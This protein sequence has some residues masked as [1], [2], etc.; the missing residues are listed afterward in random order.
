[1][2]SRSR[3]PSAVEGGDVS[4]HPLNAGRRPA[5]AFLALALVA[6]ALVIAASSAGAGGAS[7]AAEAFA[8]EVIPAGQAPAVGGAAKAPPDI[9]SLGGSFA[10][11]DDG[12]I[13]SAA[14]T[15][16]S[17]SA[18]GATVSASTRIASLSLFGG[19]ITADGVTAQLRVGGTVD[20]S[21]SGFTNLVVLGQ[22]VQAQAG[23][24]IQLADWGQ[25][26]LLGASTGTDSPLHGSLVALDVQLTADH[27]G[28]AAGSE[29]IVG[30]VS[31]TAGSAAPPITT[32][33]TP[34]PGSK[35]AVAPVPVRPP[36]QPLTPR[37]SKQA[38]GVP[39]RV[40]PP[41]AGG[42]YVF[43]V[44][45]PSSFG[46]TFGAFRA[47]VSYHHGDDIFA[48]LGT[49]L[50]AVADGTLFSVGVNPIGGNRLWLRDRAGNE[51]YYAHLSA[52]STLAH[53]GAEVHAGDVIGFVGDTGDARG[54]PYHLHF[55]IHP[56][57]YLGLGYDGAVDPTTYLEGWKHLQSVNPAELARG[58]PYLT[59]SP[60]D[61]R[62]GAIL[63][64]VTD[65]SSAS[66]LQPESLERALA[67][68]SRGQL[69]QLLA[70][71]RAAT[72][73]P[74]TPA[75]TKG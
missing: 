61:A 3:P 37:K 72:R 8:V 54:T 21:G 36:E 15:S 33:T 68:S 51:F 71:L 24:S 70:G 7:G 32:S 31:A 18:D 12:S 13:A 5:L 38:S 35:R 28:L 66:G 22:Q 62:A 14:S 47:D 19:E 58:N 55:E 26:T 17:A 75:L 41:L 59:A 34:H 1:M 6:A 50:L 39:L 67:P 16:S 9:V 64:Q 29:V 60:S 56:V 52:Y 48:P 10:D 65:I 44:F 11:P 2:R 63:L 73:P 49:P 25:A 57:G 40:T 30:F 45:G 27:G 23:A 46:D 53:D 42:P 4:I 43:P 69:R 20:T 74:S